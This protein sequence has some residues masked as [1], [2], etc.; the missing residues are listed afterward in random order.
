[1]ILHSIIQIGTAH[2]TEIKTLKLCFDPNNNQ[3]DMLL[4]TH[5]N[6][7]FNQLTKYKTPNVKRVSMAQKVDDMYNNSTL[8]K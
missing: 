1:M 5:I 8:Y 2:K 4:S 6:A 3:P 7:S